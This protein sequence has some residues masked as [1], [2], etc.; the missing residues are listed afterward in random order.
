MLRAVC[1]LQWLKK[2]RLTIRGKEDQGLVSFCGLDKSPHI[3]PTALLV[4]EQHSR[5]DLYKAVEGPSTIPLVLSMINRSY[6]GHPKRFK[7]FGCASGQSTRADVFYLGSKK[8]EEYL[9]LYW[10]IGNF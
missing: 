2:S 3:V 10:D 7:A 6:F 5:K 8:N 4:R 1:T 9:I